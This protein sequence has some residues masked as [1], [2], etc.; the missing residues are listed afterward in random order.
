VRAAALAIAALV[1]LSATGARAADPA[2]EV[3]DDGRYRFCHEKD[4]P[5]TPA[6]HAWCPLVGEKNETCP[7]LPEACKLPP[8][9]R[10][11]DFG[12]L[13]RGRGGAR[14]STGKDQS[15]PGARP[16]MDDTRRRPS[17]PILLPNLGGLAQV[18][19]IALIVAFVAV[20]ASALAKFFVRSKGEADAAPEEPKPAGETVAEAAAARGP[21]ETD[22]DRL[23]AR[24]RAEAGR[25][26]YARAIDDVY[27]ALLRR[28]DGDGLIDIHPSR[29]NGD[30]VR[31]LGERPDLKREVREVVRD[32][33]RVQ[34]GDAP[35]SEPVFRAVLGRV[36]PL[37]GRAGAAILVCLALS[38]LTS[39]TTLDRAT[40]HG[41]SEG[42]HGDPSPSGTAAL[43]ELLGKVEIDARY[44][45]GKLA[46]VS[47]KG[48][49]VLL[50]GVH[51]DEEIWAHLLR[52]VR[53]E[54]GHLVLA[55]VAPPP[56]LGM[57]LAP[58]GEETAVTVAF[59]HQATYGSYKLRVPAGERLVGDASDE[60]DFIGLLLLR[61]ERSYAVRRAE[62]EG[63]I[64]V[65]ADAQLFSNIALSVPVNASFVERLFQGTERV[66]ICDDWT[67]VGAQTP[68]ESIHK[69]QLTPVVA[70][71]FA[72]LLLLYWWRGRAFARLHDPPA[73]GRR[74]FADHAR[75]LG[76]AY[77]RAK[78]SRHVLGL[79]AVW[80]L[81]R[82]RERVH[83][84][85]RQGLVPLAEAIAA[86][87]GRSEAE[88]MAVLVEAHGAREDAAPPSSFGP[89]SMRGT[90]AQRRDEA[91]A[92]LA[93]MQQ[94]Q[95]FLAATGGRRPG[96]TRR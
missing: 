88:V 61:G 93:L 19:M 81:E 62:G 5:L 33:E 9:E 90:R 87:T 3:L 55:G 18:L 78:A 74:A 11:F 15:E 75:A 72:L 67:G 50:P 41:S 13:G 17:E 22:V 69:A 8:V 44:R 89:R 82:L 42:L 70:Q 12:G 16:E 10:R 54:G 79:Y 66:E 40:R 53:E 39:C 27:A 64:A 58:G 65:F 45:T 28:L 71:L 14:G 57:R 86:R 24:A 35:P 38:T 92:D 32:V 25:G 84:S 1:A 7:A 20:V 31:A 21:V 77:A 80:A 29:T 6:E 4:Y 2:R 26:D 83:R 30:Y 43:V 36:L 52:W 48:T 91:A 95:T 23:L 73:E 37:V 85:G 56:S 68:F 51:V 63:T 59:A 49:L 46:A 47:G 60:D 94:L 76:Q 96:R 34:F